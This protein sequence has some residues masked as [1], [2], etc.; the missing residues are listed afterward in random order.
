MLIAA[1]NGE[2]TG[3]THASNSLDKVYLCLKSGI[4]FGGATA[5]CG[6]IRDMIVVEKIDEGETVG[7][8][9]KG[10]LG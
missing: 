4:Y 1:L 10:N 3:M 7:E 5:E 9:H 2:Y 6:A 8:E